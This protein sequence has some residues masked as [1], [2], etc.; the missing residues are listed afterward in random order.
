LRALN[1]LTDAHVKNAAPGKHNDGGGLWLIKRPDGGAQWVYRFS[2]HGKRPEMGLGS[3]PTVKLVSARMQAAEW[4]QVLLSGKNPIRERERRG[5]ENAKVAPT[6]KTMTLET[7]EARKRQLV[8]DGKA[9]RWISPL[10]LHV[11]P[12]LGAMPIEE[13]DQRDIKRALGSIWHEKPETARK[14]IQR[15]GLVFKHAAAAGLDVDLQATE[16]AKALLGAQGDKVV[17]I[18]AV[19]WRDVPE[20][21]RSLDGGTPTHLALRLLILTVLRSKPI[22]FC[23]L[24][25][26][27]N[28]IW[29]VPAENMKG[30][31]G[32]AMDFR[33]PLSQEAQTIISEARKFERDGF[34][35]PS[36]NRGVISHATMSRLMERRGMKER[37][38][39]F[40]SS[41][42]T[43]CAEATDTPRE[44]A[45][46][47]LAHVSGSK[48]E[49]AYRRT[50]FLEQRRVLMERWAGHVLGGSSEVV[51]IV[52]Q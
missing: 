47:C 12:A 44:V 4:R 18:P 22:R 39:G 48:V 41:F 19:N 16:K 27:D 43:W 20:F 13:L 23:N 29:T 1:K 26:I 38:H 5:R 40:R 32:K 36:V 35:F 3:Y 17:H 50:D 6:L 49:M 34:L 51:R 15:L 11:L 37:P 8:G 30:L 21:Y 45:E 14:A 2:L 33:V 52:N 10:I 25:Q 46:T 7:F 31:K 24:E 9:G 28:D 42:R